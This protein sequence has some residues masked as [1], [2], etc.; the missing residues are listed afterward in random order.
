MHGPNV[1]KSVRRVCINGW[2]SVGWPHFHT[3]TRYS[4]F[5]IL[6]PFAQYSEYIVLYMPLACDVDARWVNTPPL[7]CRSVYY[8][9]KT[10]LL[11]KLNCG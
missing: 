4:N 11:S 9:N 2:C 1:C 5:L 8:Y 10:I 3:E 7:A 6:V